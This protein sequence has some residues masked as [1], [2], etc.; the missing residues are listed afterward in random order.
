MSRLNVNA[1]AFYDGARL[2]TL[3]A[4]FPQSEYTHLRGA[5]LGLRVGGFR[6]FSLELDWARALAAG[7]ITRLHDNKIH[8]R[9]LMEF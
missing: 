4:V 6:G 2:R 3:Q 9:L 1:V 8:A 7:D 5:G